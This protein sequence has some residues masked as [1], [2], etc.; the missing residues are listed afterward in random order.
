MLAAR[1]D[2]ATVQETMAAEEPIPGVN[3]ATMRAVRNAHAARLAAATRAQEARSNRGMRNPYN[4]M[5]AALAATNATAGGSGQQ[6]AQPRMDTPPPVP[7]MNPRERFACH[8]CGVRG[9][10]KGDQPSQCRPEDVRAHIAR[11]TAMVGQY[12]PPPNIGQL[13]LNAP[14]GMFSKIVRGYATFIQLTN[15]NNTL[16]SKHSFSKNCILSVVHVSIHSAPFHFY[17]SCT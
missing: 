4:A 3:A 5:N 13:A 14:Q 2:C 11:L 10:W 8:A 7:A 9:H 12:G 17:S 15:Y 6:S 1:Y 16:L